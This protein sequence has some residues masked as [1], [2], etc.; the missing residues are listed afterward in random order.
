MK[1]FLR[2]R[3]RSYHCLRFVY[4]NISI[5]GAI[6]PFLFKKPLVKFFS[7][8]IYDRWYAQT[9]YNISGPHVLLLTN[10]YSAMA[11]SDSLSA[12]DDYST[13]I[14][15]NNLVPIIKQTVVYDDHVRVHNY[16]FSIWLTNVS[17]DIKPY[18]IFI[19]MVRNLNNMY[20]SL[21]LLLSQS[22]F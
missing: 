7:V 8:W 20:L 4:T 5:G 1:L 22:R 12:G 18:E 3:F 11:S 16:R 17:Q 19:F 14:N 10:D 21:F 2:I 9:L 6:L 15:L 13:R